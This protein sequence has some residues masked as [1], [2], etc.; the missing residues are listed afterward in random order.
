MRLLFD[1]MQKCCR[2]QVFCIVCRIMAQLFQPAAEIAE[3]IEVYICRK[4]NQ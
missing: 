2:R 4:M 1:R 3:Q